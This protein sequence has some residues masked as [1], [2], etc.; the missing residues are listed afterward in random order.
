[1]ADDP[2]RVIIE[3]VARLGRET[4]LHLDERH[5]HFWITNVVTFVISLLL[6]VLAVFNVYYVKVLHGDLTGIVYNMD[7]M[8][9]NLRDITANMSEITSKVE[10][11]D[12]H[13]QF[14]D[15][16]YSH[17][18]DMSQSLPRIGTAM[19]E[20]S[21]EVSDINQD[22]VLMKRGMFNIE[23]KAGHMTN[24]IT[25]M[26]ENVHQIARPMSMMNSFIP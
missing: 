26:R 25:I 14:M 1:M 20:M 12:Q 24:T 4:Q 13:M 8:H 18:K 19:T 11:M 15:N 7:S 17:T 3:A 23:Q 9:T 2:R 5:R 16:I 22:M 10:S 21:G 6:V